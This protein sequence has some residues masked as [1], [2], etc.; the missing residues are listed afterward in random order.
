MKNDKQPHSCG[1][2]VAL[3][4][5]Y[6]IVRFATMPRG[7]RRR[8]KHSVELPRGAYGFSRAELLAVLA[9]P[10]VKAAIQKWRLSLLASP[11]HKEID[12]LLLRTQRTTSTRRWPL[13]T[14][15]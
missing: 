5:K 7:K 3:L 4:P 8:G 14:P 6:W 1:V 10:A 2:Q 11:V 13:A 9:T 15:A 12:A